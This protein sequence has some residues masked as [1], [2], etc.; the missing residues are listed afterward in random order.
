MRI[1]I[2]VLFLLLPLCSFATAA[3]V[4]LSVA[5]SMTDAAKELVATYQQQVGPVTL[6]PNFASSGALAKQIAQGAPA[7]IFISAN[8]KWMQ[9]LVE[10]QRVPADQVRTF[11]Y[12][13]LVFIG[14]KA[15]TVTSLADLVKLQRIAIGS[16]GSVPAGQYAVQALQAAGLYEQVPGKL[17]MAQNVRQALM[18]ADRGE[19]D[20]AFVYRTDALLARNAIILLEVPQVLYDE[21]TY[22]VG[23]TTE[24]IR[25]PAAVAF[26]D[27]LKSATA[28]GILRKHGFIVK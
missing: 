3:E 21:V 22:P 6:L 7:D 8:P 2:S 11:A 5:A 20:G 18:Y 1:L 10:E 26:F 12:N 23:L 19:T 24:G 15:L 27:F 14:D 17:V 25:N 13:A 28:A 16:P 9:F 4:R